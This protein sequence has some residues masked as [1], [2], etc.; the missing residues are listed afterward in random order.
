[1]LV[2]QAVS[3]VLKLTYTHTDIQQTDRIALYSIDNKRVI[4]LAMSKL[5]IFN[6]NSKR[7]DMEV[8]YGFLYC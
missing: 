2:S 5:Q 6:C 3:E 4:F 7:H 8:Y 1:M